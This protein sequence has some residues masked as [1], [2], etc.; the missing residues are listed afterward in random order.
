MATAVA[1]VQTLLHSFYIYIIEFT[2]IALAEN[3]SKSVNVWFA[4]K[5]RDL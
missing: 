3:S 5:T 2:S 4:I 1:S